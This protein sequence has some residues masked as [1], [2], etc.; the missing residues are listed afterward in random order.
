MWF[1][2]FGIIFFIEGILITVYGVK[3]KKRDAHIY[4]H[5][6]RH[7]DIWRCYAQIDRPLNHIRL[8]LRIYI[9]KNIRISSAKGSVFPTSL[10]SIF[11]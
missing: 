3:K 6:F 1:I 9:Q 10:F 4:R 11:L 8:L 7:Y 2:I 5:C